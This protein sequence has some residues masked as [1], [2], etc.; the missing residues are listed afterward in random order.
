[1][2]PRVS[3]LVCISLDGI[4]MTLSKLLPSG[5]VDC[6]IRNV[7]TAVDR[8]VSSTK[9]LRLFVTKVPNNYLA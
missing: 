9:I 6:E 1:M 7:P 4:D 8:M 2:K 5:L 3:A